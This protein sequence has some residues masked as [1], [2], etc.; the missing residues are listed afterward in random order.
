[1]ELLEQ[2]DLPFRRTVVA[3]LRRVRGC[4]VSEVIVG[5]TQGDTVVKGRFGQSIAVCELAPH[6]V[7]YVSL[8]QKNVYAHD[9]LF[10]GQN[11]RV[12][13]A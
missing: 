1:M 6:V 2:P 3:I 9:E 8:K 11:S 4:G 10:G 12:R 7:E 13:E 5:Q